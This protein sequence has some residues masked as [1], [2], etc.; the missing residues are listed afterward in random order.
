VT[1][2]YLVTLHN[3]EQ[4]IGPVLDSVLAEH[5]TTG[6]EIIIYD[7]AST[8]RSPVI[9]REYLAARAGAPVRVIRGEQNRGVSV[10]TSELVAAAVQ[11]Y[12]RLIDADDLLVPGSTPQLVRLL[13]KHRLGLIYGGMVRAHVRDPGERLS[14]ETPC[15]ILD[16]AIAEVLRLDFNGNPSSSL[17]RASTLT[18][19]CPLLEW[20]KR[21][22]D[23]TIIL[24]L[25]CR[26]VRI[27]RVRPVVAIAPAE[28]TGNNLSSA[29]GA[30]QAEICR[31]VAYEQAYIPLDK[32]RRTTLRYVRRARGYFQRYDAPD[33]SAADELRLWYWRQFSS[34]VSSETC[35]RRLNALA[36]FLERDA[37]PA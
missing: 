15:E 30:M 1:V 33:L 32:L 18:Q 27:G 20:I 13:R 17:F 4:F 34:L 11:P 24:R 23:F 16:D 10:A 35:V 25:A 31:T 7:D 26:G 3:K 5:A 14:L 12:I 8:D 29:T 28:Y 9:V 22:Q 2:S 37:V 19:V 6:G 21:T 36:D